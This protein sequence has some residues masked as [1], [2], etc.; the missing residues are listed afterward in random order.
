MTTTLRRRF[1]SMWCNE[2]RKKMMRKISRILA[3]IMVAVVLTV[4]FTACGKTKFSVNQASKGVVRVMAYYSYDEY[5]VDDNME[6]VF[7]GSGN[8]WGSLGSAWGVGEVGKQTKYFITNSHVVNDELSGQSFMIRRADGNY[9]IWEFKSLV[10][11]YI[12]LDDYAYDPNSETFDMSRAVPCKLLYS[13]NTSEKP[14]IA[15]LEAS[16]PVKG[17]IA[18]GFAEDIKSVDPGDTVYSIGYPSVAD[19]SSDS[20][21]YGA[22]DSQTITSGTVSQHTTM[23]S[24]YANARVIQHGAEIDSGHSGG[25]LINKDGLVVGINTW[26]YAGESNGSLNYSIETD[27]LVDILKNLRIEYNIY[28][29]NYAPIIIIVIAAIAVIALIVVLIATHGKDNKDDKK[30]KEKEKDVVPP[31]PPQ[32]GDSGFR[33][34]G[35]SGVHQGRRYAI[36]NGKPMVFGRGPGSVI[37]Y[38]DGTPGVSGTHCTVW[39]ENGKVFIKD[40]STHGTFIGQN[41]IAQNQTVQLNVGD[42]VSIGSPNERFVIASKGGV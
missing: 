28:P 21:I 30:K 23:P 7:N 8:T 1:G 38:P 10:A 17:R 27:Y 3:V 37:K 24:A 14:D 4:S 33:L 9:Y 5:R 41:R 39:T 2:G 19:I 11:Y 42:T 26:S 12:L 35:V 16:E 20:Y 36:M 13:V 31:P 34:Q 18:L 25:A 29:T 40:S 6:P 22:V 15:V 32:P